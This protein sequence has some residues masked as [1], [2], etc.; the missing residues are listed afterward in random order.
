MIEVR[1]ALRAW[2][3]G[4]GQRR[5]AERGGMNRK[6]A[7]RYIKAALQVGVVRDGGV[8]QLSDEVIGQIVGLVRPVRPDG[9]GQSWQALLP[10]QEQIT[11]WVEKDLTVVKIRDLL[12]RQGVDVPYR[13]LVR[14]CEERC[15]FVGRR[16]EETVRLADCGP[17]QECQIDF[18]EMGLLPNLATGRR[19]RTWALIFTAVH[20]RHMFVWLTHSQ[21]LEA[22]IAGCEAAWAHFGGVFRVLIPDNMKAIVTKADAV[23][24]VLSQGWLDYAQH[25][26]FVTDTTRVRRPKDKARV[27]RPVQYVRNNFWA[28]ESFVDVNDAQARVAHWASVTAGLRVHGTTH[29]RPAE[30]F[31]E[32]ER[33]ALLAVSGSYDVPEF[34]ECKV[35]RDFHVEVCKSLYSIPREYIG[36]YVQVRADS[37]LVKVSF[38]GKVIKVHP[39]MPAGK[40]ST[41]PQDMPEHKT[42]YAMRDLDR[43]VADARRHG[44]HVGT[45]AQRLLDDLPLPWTRMRTVY[46]LLG[47]ARRYG[48]DTVDTACARALELEVVNVT[49]IESMLKRAVEAAPTPAPRAVASGGRFARDPGEYAVR[50][51][52]RLVHDADAQPALPLDGEVA[53]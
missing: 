16:P 18:G 13:T 48:S 38:R 50:G 45:Y 29:E 42:A 30:A 51:H 44:E 27:E 49:K 37:A 39:R 7:E 33:A 21:T 31:T 43:L 4:L 10:W 40:P 47:L 22:I 46:R 9:H 19:R 36:Q 5:A 35:H 26:G 17:G 12:C 32:R 14:F 34:K 8:G 2:L 23:N 20:S 11:K 3:S 41:D 15:G 6:T 52:L 1:E 53:R 25:R 24:P 28:G